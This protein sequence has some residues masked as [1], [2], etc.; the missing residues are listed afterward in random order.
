M[1]QI[2]E[3]VVA[4]TVTILLHE[5]CFLAVCCIVGS[6][7]S[8]TVAAITFLFPTS[9]MQARG[10]NTRLI[11]STLFY[12]VSF[13]TSHNRPFCTATLQTWLATVHCPATREKVFILFKYSCEP[14]IPS[15]DLTVT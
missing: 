12:L 3:C 6:G 11:K 7:H 2:D 14:Q 9:G 4:I 15:V 10:R 5:K 8:W 13:G 1:W